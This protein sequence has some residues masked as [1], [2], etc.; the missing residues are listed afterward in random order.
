MTVTGLKCEV[1]DVEVM[2]LVTTFT[3]VGYESVQIV[4]VQQS[5]EAA[6]CGRAAAR[7]VEAS[8]AT[9][10]NCML[11]DVYRM[12]ESMCSARE[13]MYRQRRGSVLLMGGGWDGMR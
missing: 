8:S 6:N 2:I 13:K 10:M 12:C 3:S 4:D 1:T 7:P 5:S 11:A 9:V